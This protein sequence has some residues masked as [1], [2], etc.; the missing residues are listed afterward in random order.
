MSIQ[1]ALV[2]DDSKTA[3]YRLKK[4]LLR[5]P[6]EIDIASSAEEALGYLS[7]R[8]PVVIFMDHHME[9]MDGFEALKIIKA[10]PSTAK[11]P[12][13]MYTSQSG[14]VYVG[15]AYALGAL[16]ILS[17]DV[18]KPDN[19]EDVLS[20]LEIHPKAEGEDKKESRA[21]SIKAP[22]PE[23]EKALDEADNELKAQIARLFELH[24]ADVRTQIS[25]HT[26]FIVRRL[27]GEIEQASQK[28]VRVDDVPLSVI[29]GEAESERARQNLMSSSLL[30]LILMALSAITFQLYRSYKQAEDIENSYAYLA[31]LSLQENMLLDDIISNTQKQLSKDKSLDD[32]SLLNALSWAMSV[33]LRYDFGAPPLGDAQVLNLQNFVYKLSQADF[34]GFIELNIHLGNY[35]LEEKDNGTWQLAPENMSVLECTFANEV[36]PLLAIENYLSVPYIQFE[37]STPPIQHGDIEIILNLSGYDNSLFDY[38]SGDMGTAGEW[39]DVAKQNNQLSLKIEMAD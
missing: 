23:P 5:F 20:K 27:S 28:E 35:C 6:L 17:K 33:D 38:P 31:D 9:G 18:F 32:T 12:V 15:Q 3:Q 25:E 11:I 34:E 7:Y 1:R 36:S 16:D 22:A 30:L 4:M 14:D 24:V 39:N 37:Q 19:L 2:V 13:I 21:D 10:N 29:N 8:M 26:K